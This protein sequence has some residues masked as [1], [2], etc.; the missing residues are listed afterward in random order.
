MREADLQEGEL[1][2]IIASD[3][4]LSSNFEANLYMLLTAHSSE[5]TVAFSP[6]QTSTVLKITILYKCHGTSE[7]CVHNL[8]PNSN[9]GDRRVVCL[10]RHFHRFATGSSLQILHI[11]S[12]KLLRC[13]REANE[14]FC[15]VYTGL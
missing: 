6:G 13:I 15:R 11:V 1:Y 10:N 4:I 2:S 8:M 12:M 14:T 3:Q 7:A 9:K 5:S